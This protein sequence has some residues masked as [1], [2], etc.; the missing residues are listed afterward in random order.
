MILFHLNL[1]KRKLPSI[2]GK[3]FSKH[4]NQYMRRIFI[5]FI[6][7]SCLFSCQK[8]K[9]QVV[10]ISTTM[11]DIK[12]KLYNET[13]LHRDNFIKLVKEKFYDGV[14][15][16]R[17][18]N[19]FMI[20]A[21]DPDSKN[22]TPEARLGSGNLGYTIPAEFRPELF[23]RKG[24]L[25]AARQ[26]DQVN[27]ERASSASQFYIVQGRKYASGDLEKLVEGANRSRKAMV[28][29][30]L[31]KKYDNE[32]KTLQAAKDKEGLKALAARLNSMGDSLFVKEKLTLTWAQK[33]A[34][35]SEG[36]IPHLDGQY[37]V[38]GEV[39]EGM[40]VMEKIAEVKTD[41]QDRPYKD[42][43]IKSMELQ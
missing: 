29:R 32:I 37:T 20:Q 14:L 35:T 15:F 19:N 7:L 18:I 39:I 25:A 40:D 21:G 11:G 5:S 22:A 31:T 1:Y 3:F 2:R 27:P 4:V 26:A 6:L 41:S 33:R 30:Q 34:Y 12:V 38:F 23:H 36:G 43:V 8:E 24:V 16:H 42:V 9:E 17:V 28:L 13:P 10:K